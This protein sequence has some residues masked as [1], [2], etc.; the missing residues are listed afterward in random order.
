VHFLTGNNKKCI[1]FGNAY[2]Q[3][4]GENAEI[5]FYIGNAQIRDRNQPAGLQ[6]L[7]KAYRLNPELRNK[8]LN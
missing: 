4:H 8:K 3:T 1:E 5:Y 2:L 6:N 7:E